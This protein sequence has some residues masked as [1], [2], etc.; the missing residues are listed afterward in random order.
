MNTIHNNNNFS[1]SN[2]S[3]SENQQKTT[4]NIDK[5]SGAKTDNDSK[6]LFEPGRT[7][8]FHKEKTALTNSVQKQ[9]TIHIINSEKDIL[10]D[11][12]FI[13]SFFHRSFHLRLS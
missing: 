9:N 2:N 13:N 10:K 5:A 7:N 8:N 12:I 11:Q 3:D 6:T 1:K 4:N